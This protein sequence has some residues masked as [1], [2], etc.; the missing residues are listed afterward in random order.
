MMGEMTTGENAGL[1]VVS[2][3]AGRIVSPLLV[4]G[5]ID[6][7][8]RLLPATHGYP[9]CGSSRPPSR[10]GAPSARCARRAAPGRRA[11]ARARHR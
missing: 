3:T 9:S 6:L 7:G 11:R 5:A 10:S 8:A 1:Y 4:G 2:V